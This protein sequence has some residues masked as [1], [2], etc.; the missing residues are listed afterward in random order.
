MRAERKNPGDM[1]RYSEGA[2]DEVRR[3]QDCLNDLIS[4]MALPALW[5][6]REPPDI[7]AALLD[8]LVRMLRLEFARARLCDGFASA[9][10]IDILRPEDSAPAD[11]PGLSTATFRLGVQDALGDI[12]VGSR[13]RGFP[14]EIERLLIQV[15]ANQAAI[16][17]QEA[18]RR[19]DQRRAAR[20]LER[21]VAERTEELTRVNAALRNEIVE[22]RRVEEE[23]LMLASLVDNSTDFIGIASLAGEV[24]FLNAA[25]QDLAG[26]ASEGEARAASAFDFVVE[27]D[28]ERVRADIWPV[29]LRD[30]RWD[31]EL[32]FTNLRTR[33]SFPMHTHAFVIKDSQRGSPV[34]V[35]TIS[36]DITQRKHAEA[37]LLRAREELA[38]VSRVTTMGELTA[39]IAHEV[40]QPLAALVANANACI[41][42]LAA[43]P[44]NF[45]E[46]HAAAKR[47]IRDANRASEVMMRIRSFLTRA[48]PHH[49]PLEV[50][51]AIRD[52]V[53]IVQGEARARRV[54]LVA[55]AG[56][57]LPPVMGDRVQLQQVMLN[58]AMNAIEAMGAVNDRERFLEIGGCLDPA[59]E[60]RVY[61]RD[62]GPGLDEAQR[63]RAFDA[64]YTTKPH[65]MGMGLAISRSIVETHGGRLW[66]ER[67]PGAGETFQFTLP[68]KAA[69]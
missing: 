62:T 38:H 20:E 19:N 66:S 59:D 55:A 28:R 44:S 31:G 60:V 26:M 15:G 63:E 14:S 25:G 47:I 33:L 32:R 56:S 65:G 61:V 21:R 27:E 5:R 54:R 53:S 11:S 43:E 8:G 4:V 30:G 57:D 12:V 50:G 49:A 3:L 1:T 67:N 23:R 16:A 9:P 29:V 68:T 7:V 48:K 35:A 52:V 51:E 18:R 22:R 17:L 42:W 41:H 13:R 37:E 36:R 45:D 40:N 39:T 2:T 64:F 24:L 34:A 46:V 6:G 69:A 58:L 10:P